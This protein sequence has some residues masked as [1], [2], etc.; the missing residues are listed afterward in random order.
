M[1]PERGPRIHLGGEGWR[2]EK[3]SCRCGDLLLLETATD[4]LSRNTLAAAEV[5]KVWR[6]LCNHYR[7]VSVHSEY[8][9]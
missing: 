3:A 2:P 8:L 7:G 1:S 6:K 9:S 4:M 5:D